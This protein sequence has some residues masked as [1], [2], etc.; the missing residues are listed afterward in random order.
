MNKDESQV[1]AEKWQG[2]LKKF[3]LDSG[4]TMTKMAEKLQISKSLLSRLESG[5]RIINL[6]QF[7]AYLS[8][9]DIEIKPIKKKQPVNESN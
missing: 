8:I 4:I 3:R 9:L 1:Y 6:S 7:L 5:E 2:T